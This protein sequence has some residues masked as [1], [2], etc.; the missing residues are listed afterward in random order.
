[1]HIQPL[2]CEVSDVGRAV[3]D[4]TG[5]DPGEGVSL[6]RAGIVAWCT[7][8][9]GSISVHYFLMALKGLETAFSVWL[10]FL[11][12]LLEPEIDAVIVAV[13]NS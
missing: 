11:L 3:R 4:R 2:N 5:P 7:H 6:G 9:P 12:Y 1:M 10:Q 13:R 8:S